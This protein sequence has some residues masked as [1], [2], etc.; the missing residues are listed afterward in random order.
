[1]IVFGLGSWTAEANVP[2]SSSTE[3]VEVVGVCR[4]N[5]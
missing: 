5:E 3:V 1:V 4:D 2:K